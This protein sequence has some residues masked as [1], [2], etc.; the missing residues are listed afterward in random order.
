[1][2]AWPALADQGAGVARDLSDPT[3]P[4]PHVDYATRLHRLYETDVGRSREFLLRNVIVLG[5]GSAVGIVAEDLIV[6]GWLAVYYT[7]ITVNTLHLRARRELSFATPGQWRIGVGLAAAAGVIYA[8]LPLYLWMLPDLA[9]NFVAAAGIFGLAMLNLTRHTFDRTLARFDMA[10]VCGAILIM[11]GVA[12]RQIG[13]NGHGGLILAGSLACAAYYAVA[14][15]DGLILRT[16]LLSNERREAQA[17]K[18]QAV[19]QLTTGIA[20]DFNNILTVVIGNIEL[21][22]LSHDRAE[23]DESLTEAHRAAERA[24]SLVAQLLAFS[25]RAQLR[26]VAINPQ[27]FADGFV[28]TIARLLPAS[29]TLHHRVA[30]G[31][32]PFLC[33]RTLLETALL[34]LVI[35]ARDAMTGR[36]K[37]TILIDECRLATAHSVAQHEIAPGH[38][39]CITLSDSGTGISPDLLGRVAEPFFTTKSIGKGSG[40]GLA[41]VKGFSEQSGGGLDIASSPKGTDI[42]LYLPMA[43]NTAQATRE[44]VTEPTNLPKSD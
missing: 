8:M 19:G 12:A 40:L 35:N 31:M 15:Q 32:A 14:H 43:D 39:A 38:Y 13:L 10:V 28:R 24:S 5:V 44:T 21:A 27:N 33:D 16:R 23:I 1:L 29:I 18:M 7:V 37:L 22:R 6:F 34:N 2:G 41:M 9:L 30:P 36:G 42:T 26:P 3:D 20:H 11:G 17:A 4:D 25:R